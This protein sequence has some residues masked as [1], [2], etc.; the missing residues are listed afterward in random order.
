[1]PLNR[2]NPHPASAVIVEP[3]APVSRELF[4]TIPHAAAP[5]GSKRHVGRGILVESSGRVA[6][7]RAALAQAT[8]E[9]VASATPS[10]W[11]TREP[12]YVWANFTCVRPAS[13]YGTGRNEYR[14]KDSAPAFPATRTTGDIDKLLRA[15]L[16][17]MQD[18]GAFVDDSQVVYAVAAK[19]WGSAPHVHVTV[20]LAR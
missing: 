18:G 13:H 7:Y 6:P 12:V 2:H 8:H 16:D 17:A 14:V 20:K 15:T 1:M 10:T 9:A 4:V 19:T 3:T 5:Q 11:P